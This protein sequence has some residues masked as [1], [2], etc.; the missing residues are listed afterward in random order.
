LPREQLLPTEEH[1]EFPL[2]WMPRWGSWG[3]AGQRDEPAGGHR[4]VG[5]RVLVVGG[6]EVPFVVV[7]GSGQAASLHGAGPVRGSPAN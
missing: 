5:P 4:Q 6:A 1:S 7:P 3:Q 2:G